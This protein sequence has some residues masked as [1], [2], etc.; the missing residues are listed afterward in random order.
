MEPAQKTPEEP[1]HPTETAPKA[2]NTKQHRRKH[3]KVGK[4]LEAVFV[5]TLEAASGGILLLADGARHGK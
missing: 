4:Q 3:R 5:R 1:G 2:E